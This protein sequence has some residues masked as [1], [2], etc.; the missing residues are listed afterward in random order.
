MSIETRHAPSAAAKALAHPASHGARAGAGDAAADAA[1]NGFMAILGGL[2]DAP[3]DM[4]LPSGGA[5]AAL[6][7]DQGLAPPVFDASL[8]LQQNPQIAA[9][10]AQAQAQQAAAAAAA[11]V[12]DASLLLQ[13]N[14]Q[15]AAAQVQ[16]AAAAAAVAQPT[17]L[18]SAAAS[19]SGA[20]VGSVGGAGS[21][22][23]GVPGKTAA[24]PVR[25]Q[26][27]ADADAAAQP[28][29][30]VAPASGDIPQPE[31]SLTQG[32]QHAGSQA[33]AARESLKAVADGAAVV[34]SS[35]IAAP[36]ATERSAAENFMAA[37]QHGRAP[38][39][40]RA[41][42]PLLA[43]LLA[44]PEKPQSERAGFRFKLEEPTYSG[45]TLG[46]GAPD[47]SQ[48]GAPAPVM[49]PELQVAEQVRYWVSQN[50]QNA[51][52]K[53][54][55]LGLSPVQVSISVQGHEAQI[56]FRSDDAATRDMLEGAGAHLK[57][58]LQ[59]E[60]LLLTGVSVGGSGNPG[61]SGNG[62]A[63]GGERR[64]RQNVRQ[65]VMAPLQAVG[66]GSGPRL[67]TDAGRS[68]DLFV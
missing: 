47:F 40:E 12:F 11:P 9:A 60:G 31:P 27:V 1:G 65:G 67:R 41:L 22:A 62:E 57:G 35:G 20:G 29:G 52:L 56:V 68:V 46:V 61:S 4:A 13:Q 63:G 19:A 24:A 53:L 26:A 5:G 66:A 32:L 8:L 28:A 37:L 38:Q 51:E 10:Q 6:V 48:S 2:G 34:N 54:D 50:V 14:P 30:L 3:A 7:P 15:I 44:K 43:P 49:A 16:Q 45:T 59:A 21:A 55:G 33:R 58:M 36:A 42:E 39:G 64:S 18:A 23:S 17:A 25:S